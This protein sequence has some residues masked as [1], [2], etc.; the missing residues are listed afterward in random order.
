MNFSVRRVAGLLVL[1]MVTLSSSAQDVEAIVADLATVEDRGPEITGGIA[2]DSRFYDASG[3]GARRDNH[4]W[5]A[6]ANLTLSLGGLQAPFSF[7]FSD[8]NRNFNLPAYTFTGISPRYKWAT[9]HAG[10]RA[11]ALSP[12]T[13][14]GI[15]FRGAGV[16]LTPG[17]L[18]FK[19]F[20]GRLNRA[21]AADLDALGNLNGFYRRDGYGARLGYA[22]RGFSYALNYFAA[23]DDSGSGGTLAPDAG[24]S[25]VDN[26]VLSLEGRQQ[27]GKRVSLG[28]EYARSLFNRDLRAAALPAGERNFGN[29]LFGLFTPTETTEVGSAYN[30]NA[31]YG[32][33]RLGLRLG[34]ERV[35]RGFRT[36][37]ALFFNNDT[38]HL[39]AGVNYS[40]LENRLS[41]FVNTG[42]EATN[43]DDRE[44]ESTKRLIGSANVSYRPNDDW[45]Y[46]L[47]FSNFRNDTKLR[48]A[49]DLDLAVDSIF[50][51]QVTRATGGSVTRTFGTKDRPA[52]LNLML[53]HQRANNVIND[54]VDA[55]ART[56][57]TVAALTYAGGNPGLGLRY[58]AGLTFNQTDL[59]GFGATIFTPTAGLTKTF[60]DGDVSTN[61]RTSLSFV[62]QD[63]GGDNRI[64]NL[65]L[66][67]SYRLANSHRITFSGTFLDRSGAVDPSRNFREIYAQ[68][69]YGFNFGGTL[70]SLRRTVATDPQK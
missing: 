42:V 4:Q 22:D 12:Y 70:Q 63:A 16:E 30:L 3:I 35:T 13:M 28:G 47:N 59:A 43:L 64:L 11:M 56:R 54:E 50:L 2:L 24:L 41:F 49:T 5:S 44:L 15:S 14:S 10:D 69:G 55:A 26:T 29:Q 36:L 38:E 6:R 23:R 65:G 20:Y 18:E 19:T 37:G 61:A 60:L 45:N 17:K 58:H 25:P 21:L 53:N 9:V 7:V 67:G 40:L 48:A 39:T 31:Y 1:V 62:Q 46:S 33:D 52:N 8:A 34:Y 66:G 51:A 27:V 68:L 32:A 57:F